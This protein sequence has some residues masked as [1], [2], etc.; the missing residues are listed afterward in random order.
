MFLSDA[1]IYESMFTSTNCQTLLTGSAIIVAIF[2]II[3]LALIK[4][5]RSLKSSEKKNNGSA[6]PKSSITNKL[7]Y[8][9]FSGFHE[10][11]GLLA[12]LFT[13]LCFYWVQLNFNDTS[14]V[15]T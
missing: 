12:Q 4:L 10:L 2:L 8:L 11:F 6:I 9:F 1:N 7:V 3:I 5:F 14:Q 15:Q 13:A